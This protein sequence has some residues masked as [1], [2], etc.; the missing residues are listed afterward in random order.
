VI[1]A[2]PPI[3][4]RHRAAPPASLAWACLLLLAAPACRNPADDAAA[5]AAAAALPAGTDLLHAARA[6]RAE[7]G[8]AT[9]RDRLAHALAARDASGGALERALAAIQRDPG[10]VPPASLAAL[11]AGLRRRS[12]IFLVLGYRQDGGGSAEIVRHTAATLARAGWQARLIPL[13]AWGTADQDAAAIQDCLARELPALDRAMVVG[14][15]KGGHDWIHWLA[16][17]ASALPLREREKIR[18]WVQFAGALRGSPIST[19]I[20]ENPGPGAALFRGVLNLS[21]KGT[22]ESFADLS[23]L[24]EDPWAR[25]PT[26]PA[27]QAILP[28]A[29]AIHFVALPNGLDGHATRHGLFSALSRAVAKADPMLG[30]NDGLV[31]S[32]AQILPPGDPTPQTIVRVFGSHALL[33]GRYAIGGRRVARSYD[34]P[35]PGWQCAGDH[36][37]DDLMRALPRTALG[38]P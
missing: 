29:S 21:A 37:L 24:G 9:A 34:P 36:L 5:R 2:R 12:G 26:P 15:S 38:W 28:R 18:L 35:R 31:E 7:A 3:H 33:D 8:L 11:P 27:L 20:A 23:G 4:A 6:W 1:P 32:A 10:H 30:P 16:G 22:R 17:P 14:F 19:W 13:P 25:P